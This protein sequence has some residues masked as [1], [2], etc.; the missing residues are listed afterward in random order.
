[1]K[2]TSNSFCGLCGVEFRWFRPE[3]LHQVFKFIVPCDVH[4]RDQIRRYK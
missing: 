1:M 2:F 4:L 3:W